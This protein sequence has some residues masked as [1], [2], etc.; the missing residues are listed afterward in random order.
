LAVNKE[1]TGEMG[2]DWV[3]QVW[4]EGERIAVLEPVVGLPETYEETLVVREESLDYFMSKL[5]AAEKKYLDEN[6]LGKD[7]NWAIPSLP[8]PQLIQVRLPYVNR[9]FEG[10]YYGDDNGDVVISS[11]T[12]VQMNGGKELDF[13]G[14]PFLDKW[15][16]FG[17][18]KGDEN[19][20]WHFVF[21]G[22]AAWNWADG[23]PS[24]SESDQL[25]FKNKTKPEHMFEIFNEGQ[26]GFNARIFIDATEVGGWEEEYGWTE[27]IVQDFIKEWGFED[28]DILMDRIELNI[29]EYNEIMGKQMVYTRQEGGVQVPGGFLEKME[30]QLI[31]SLMILGEDF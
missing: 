20:I 24:G 21:D 15:S 27:S 6:W 18:S 28:I 22:D 14:M 26:G 19:H 2:V 9:W 10:H 16:H 29:P 8:F 13:V 17:S 3:E 5:L 11:W 25:I 30:E 31:P 7:I 4:V 12:R 1:R 23:T